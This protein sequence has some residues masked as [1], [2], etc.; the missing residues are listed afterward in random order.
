VPRNPIKACSLNLGWPAWPIP[1]GT[2]GPRNPNKAC[3]L[4]LFH[5]RRSHSVKTRLESLMPWLF[6]GLGLN[7][8]LASILVVPQS[9]FAASGCNCPCGSAC[10]PALGGDPNG[11][12]CQSCLYKCTGGITGY[13]VSCCQSYCQNAGNPLACAKQCCVTYCGSNQNCLNLCSNIPPPECCNSSN[14]CAGQY[15]SSPCIDGTYPKCNRC[16]QCCIAILGK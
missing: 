12:A 6:L 11:T 7:L 10:D 13:E 9:A 15:P 2:P 16:S 3:S 4:N 14:D 5:H 1:T 8:L